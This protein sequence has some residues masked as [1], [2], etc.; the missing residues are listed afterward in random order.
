[1]QKIETNHLFHI[2]T[3]HLTI[4]GIPQGSILSSQL[5]LFTGMTTTINSPSKPTLFTDNGIITSYSGICHFQNCLSDIFCHWLEEM[6]Q[7]QWTS[8]RK[9]TVSTLLAN[10]N[11]AWLVMTANTSFMQIA[12]IP[13][14]IYFH[15]ITTYIIIFWKSS[16]TPTKYTYCCNNCGWQI[17]WKLCACIPT[18]PLQPYIHIHAHMNTHKTNCQAVNHRSPAAEA[19]I[20]PHASQCRI[21]GG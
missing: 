16:T 21:C 12:V 6:V 20:Q 15:S 18:S 3:H 11:L 4:Y 9:P 5:L 1:M 7:S 17:K 10:L 13:W 8:S 19:G 2:T 14:S